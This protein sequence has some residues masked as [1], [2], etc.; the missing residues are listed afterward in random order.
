MVDP[1]GDVSDIQSVLRKHGLTLE[2]ILVTHGH[3]DHFL[4]AQE[5]KEKERCQARV[6]LNGEA[7]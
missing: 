7:L 1:G 2:S 3:F 6:R 5:L 4:G